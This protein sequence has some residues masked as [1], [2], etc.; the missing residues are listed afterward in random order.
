[1]TGPGRPGR[2]DQAS[3]TA[4]GAA[5]L[6]WDYPKLLQEILKTASTLHDLRN[7]SVPSWD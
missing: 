1:M 5:A 2:E 6:G 3:L 7:A 4:L